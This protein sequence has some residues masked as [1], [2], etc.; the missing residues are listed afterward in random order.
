[1]RVVG[2]LFGEMFRK[3]SNGRR[4]GRS[5]TNFGTFNV[6]FGRIFVVFQKL[7]D[8]FDFFFS[9]NSSSSDVSEQ[10]SAILHEMKRAKNLQVQMKKCSIFVINRQFFVFRSNFARS[11][12]N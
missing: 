5:E 6:K 2:R 12:R 10:L 1:M 4:I 8:F 7:M 9:K 3:F 11:K